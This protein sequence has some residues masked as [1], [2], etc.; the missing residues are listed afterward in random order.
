MNGSPIEWL[1]SGLV[2]RAADH[3]T[4]VFELCERVLEGGKVAP[5]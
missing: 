1:L 5:D 3:E 4:A 2:L